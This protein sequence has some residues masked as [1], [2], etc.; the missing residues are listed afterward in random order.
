MTAPDVHEEEAL[1]KAYDGRLMR[2]L[3]RYARPYRALVIGSLVLLL[4]DGALQLVGPAL[5]QRVIDIAIPRGDTQLVVTSAL[6]FAAT[7]VFQFVFTFGETMLTSLLGQ[8]VMSASRLRYSILSRSSDP[9]TRPCRGESLVPR[10]SASTRSGAPA[11]SIDLS[12]S[13]TEPE[14]TSGVAT[15]S[16]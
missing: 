10:M 11:P 5:T 8:R 6:L 3:L 4:A 1:G 15:S 7:L 12:I 13:A 16:W 14:S 2:R 9:E